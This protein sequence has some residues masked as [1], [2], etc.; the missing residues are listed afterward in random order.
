VK[1]DLVVNERIK[2]CITLAT[3]GVTYTHSVIMNPIHYKYFGP[4]TVKLKK[5]KKKKKTVCLCFGDGCQCMGRSMDLTESDTFVVC[6]VVYGFWTEL[7]P[8]DF[9][10]EF[11]SGNLFCCEFFSATGS[12]ES[13]SL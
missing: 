5:E 7:C 12:D 11:A 6:Q 8:E 10:S 4:N 13:C 1:T 9:S 3:F 2:V